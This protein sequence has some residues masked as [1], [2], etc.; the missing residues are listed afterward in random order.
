MAGLKDSGQA[1]GAQVL[2][3]LTG[4][5][6][7]TIMAQASRLMARQ[8]MFNVVVTNVPGPAVPA[9][10]DGARDARPVPDGSARP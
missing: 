10:P 8:R 5:A 4:F 7:P 9:L 6:P 1:V 3:R 2:T